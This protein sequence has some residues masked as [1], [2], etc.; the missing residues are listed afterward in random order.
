M[1]GSIYLFRI[2]GI[3]LRMHVTFPLILVWVAVQFGVL[4]GQGL[5]GALFGVLITLLLFV[6]VVLHELGHSYAA[7]RYHIPV[8]QIV[9]LPIGGVAELAALPEDPRQELVIALAGPAVNFALAALLLPVGL[10]LGYQP[11]SFGALRTMGAG[12]GLETIFSYLYTSN[13]FLGIFNLLP[14]FP[15]DGGR[16]L[17]ALLAI[18]LEYTLATR[19]AAAVGQ[20]LAWLIGLWGFLGGGLFVILLAVFIYL[21]AGQE[22]QA[23]QTRSV[24]RRL[25]V[26]QAFS[27]KVESLAPDDTLRQAI[28]LTLQSF[29]ADFPV[30]QDGRLVGLLTGNDLIQALARSRDELPV[31]QVMRTT[32][33]TVSPD[34]DLFEAQQRLAEH[35]IDALPI[36][37]EGR[38]VGLL[39]SRDLNEV[40]RLLLLNRVPGAD[41]A[42]DD[43]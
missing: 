25:H 21:G 5:A 16:V 37:E 40:Y 29:Q 33:P 38:F 11:L 32:F 19:I 1:G 14:A 30:L 8:K 2:W 34:D 36:L 15:M 39:T 24:L 27:R 13:L 10:L 43:R 12:G 18:R 6:V 42:P 3:D 28:D 20:A 22:S 7:L 23:V 26:R 35:K 4:A 41:P 31:S 17:R 9:L